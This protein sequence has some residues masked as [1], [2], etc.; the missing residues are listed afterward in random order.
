M[1]ATVK[2]AEEKGSWPKGI[3]P[4]FSLDNVST[5]TSAV[6]KDRWQQPGSW[7]QNNLAGSQLFMP[8]PYSPDLH[9]VVEHAI[10]NTSQAFQKLLWHEAV[11]QQTARAEV[12]D[13][14]EMLQQAFKA[15]C[16]PAA[17]RRNVDLLPKVWA[18]VDS[19]GGDWAPRGLR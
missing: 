3:Q 5:H 10:A 13:Y 12:G 8:P 4:M 16:T 2:E 14:E 1:R 11:Q 9:Q 6:E 19:N 18:G 7:W 15:A 17:I